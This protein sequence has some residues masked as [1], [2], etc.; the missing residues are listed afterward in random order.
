MRF[1]YTAKLIKSHR[2]WNVK[3]S[4][5]S[6]PPTWEL[7]GKGPTIS[8]NSKERKLLLLLLYYYNNN[9]IKQ[10]VCNTMFSQAL[11]LS[12]SELLCLMSSASTWLSVIA[13][14]WSSSNEAQGNWEWCLW[15]LDPLTSASFAVGLDP[16]LSY[17][18]FWLPSAFPYC[19]SPRY[20]HHRFH[21][22]GKVALFCLE[23]IYFTLYRRN[24]R[25]KRHFLQH[26]NYGFLWL[27]WSCLWGPVFSHLET[28][29]CFISPFFF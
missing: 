23:T 1:E 17:Q 5:L 16:T 6:S 4:P 27:T 3:Y 29:Y 20:W 22:P 28:V 21:S 9:I 11:M 12:L 13:T 15:A 2:L 18:M 25:R 19:L 7:F 26:Q 14:L 8:R 24:K 10:T